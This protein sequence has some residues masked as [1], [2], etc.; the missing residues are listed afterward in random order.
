LK[1]V[2][3]AGH[4]DVTSV[5]DKLAEIRNLTETPVCVGFGI[6][7]AESAKAVAANADGAVV[8]SVLVDKMG[9]LQGESVETICQAL[10]ELVAPI[11]QGLDEL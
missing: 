9:S 6:K 7:D 3:G 10:A 5:K 11:R 8:G 2:T 1:G 4:L